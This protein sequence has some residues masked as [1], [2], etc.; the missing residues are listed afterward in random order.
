MS[1][2]GHQVGPA[3]LIAVDDLNATGKSF[4]GFVRG[5]IQQETVLRSPRPPIVSKECDSRSTPDLF[6]FMRQPIFAANERDGDDGREAA[7][8]AIA[9]IGDLIIEVEGG[10]IVQ[11]QVGGDGLGETG[12]EALAMAVEA[13]SGLGKAHACQQAA[14]GANAAHDRE[15]RC[16][17]RRQKNPRIVHGRPAG[18]VPGARGVGPLAVPIS[19]YSGAS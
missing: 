5:E 19:L 1:L 8:T 3:A 7:G 11:S 18:F 6:V 10:R 9:K 17:Y 13:T 4:Q 16:G 15:R 12:F 14:T 2:S